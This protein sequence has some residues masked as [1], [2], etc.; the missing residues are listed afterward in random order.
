MS[1]AISPIAM[2]TASGT[3]SPGLVLVFGAFFWYFLF[4]VV[5][6]L[7]VSLA[8]TQHLPQGRCQAGDRHS[9]STRPGATSRFQA[10]VTSCID[11]ADSMR[12]A[13]DSAESCA[14]YC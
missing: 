7:G 8:D 6:F 14:T 3:A 12:A 4:T 10:G 2:V 11:E 9:T 5:P 1:S 13:S